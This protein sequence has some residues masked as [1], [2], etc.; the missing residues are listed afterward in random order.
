M[1][2]FVPFS[3]R[4][5]DISFFVF[6]PMVVLVDELMV[7]LKRFSLCTETMGCVHSAIFKSIHGNM[8]IWYGSWI[9]RSNENKET[10][11]ATLLSMLSSISS[12][13]ILVDHS[14]FEAYAGESRDGSPAAK[15]STGDTISMS[16]MLFPKEHNEDVSYA[17]LAIFKSR[18]AKM[19]GAISGVCLESQSQPRTIT[20]FVWKS[21]Q[22]CYSWIL[23]SDYRKTVLPYID[24]LPLEIK[25]DIFKVVYVSRDNSEVSFQL[26]HSH[27]ML[28][29]EVESEEGNNKM[30]QD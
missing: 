12:M 21:L 10:L 2:C 23:T 5:L 8:I 26:N 28:E 24:N 13:A 4:N 22:S 3:K 18:F 17:S 29:T 27:Q 16:A 11:N 6:R 15:F 20:L 30:I 19:D 25:Y 14:F 7:A 9:K 1:A